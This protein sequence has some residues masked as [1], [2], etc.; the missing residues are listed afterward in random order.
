MK[1]ALANIL[2]SIAL[3]HGATLHADTRAQNCITCHGEPAKHALESVHS[4][5]G[6][7]C[8]TCHGG[9]AGEVDVAK[10]HG[11]ALRPLRDARQSVETCGGCHSDV[12][13]MRHF[14]LRTD[15]LS[16][17]WTSQHGAALA[18]KNDAG[19]ATCVSCHGSHDVLRVDDPLSP[20]HPRRQP[21]TCGECHSDADRMVVHGLPADQATSFRQSVHG[22]ALFERSQS[23]A[24][25]CA[26]CHGSHG[27][28]PPRVWEIE[29][30]CGG[31]HSV[32]QEYYERSPHARAAGAKAPVTCTA[33]H[34]DHGARQPSTE[35]FVG[36]VEGS[37]VACHS[38]E[39]DKGFAVA[40][41][42]DS[43]VRK[44][45]ATIRGADGAIAAAAERGLFLG[46][47]RGYL[48]EARGLLVRARTMTHTL[49]P[50]ALDDVLNRG[51]A[52]V[53][54]T[55]ENLATKNRIFRDRKIFTAIFFAVS[56]AFAIALSMHAHE[57]VGKWKRGGVGG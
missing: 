13:Q 39:T 34:G 36:S 56:I 3:V 44:L 6:L 51:Q 7:D 26:S 5:A 16:L 47:E 29:G 30:T 20:T 24:P 57:L 14:G 45:E 9:N 53:D 55:L 33:C 31:C 35:M 28:L 27:A 46:I 17:Y 11:D 32:V 19:V 8:I 43:D 48:E 54:Q 42:L 37:C 4:R 1:R 21:E 15:Q 49:D 23:A 2:V 22:D 10:A 40:R 52:M 12:N 50:D 38:E 41:R 18:L 25:S